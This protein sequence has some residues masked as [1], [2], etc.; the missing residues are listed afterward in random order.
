MQANKHSKQSTASRHIEQA[1]QQ[2]L[3]DNAVTCTHDANL[4][5]WS[6]QCKH[7]LHQINIIYHLRDPMLYLQGQPSK[8]CILQSH[9]WIHTT[10][11]CAASHAQALRQ[12]LNPV[13]RQGHCPAVV[14]GLGMRPKTDKAHEGCYA[15][16]GICSLSATR[17]LLV[18]HFEHG[19]GKHQGT[20]VYRCC[21]VY[22]TV[23]RSIALLLT[24]MP[25]CP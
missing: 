5:A 10:L 19:S 3:C 9:S 11:Y 21:F 20:T 22:R 1:Q 25:K 24:K 16:H 7:P 18:W 23:P 13:S 2:H 12:L 6:L 17:V 14:S 8:H 4:K 15:R